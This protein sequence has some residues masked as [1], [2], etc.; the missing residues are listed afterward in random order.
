MALVD[1]VHA[2]PSVLLKTYCL[3]ETKKDIVTL[4][5][6]NDREC[7]KEFPVQL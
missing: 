7:S 2:S 1:S 4:Q 3:T 6:K 5:I